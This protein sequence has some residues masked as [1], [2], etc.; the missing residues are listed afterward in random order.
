MKVEAKVTKS[1]P[2]R[3][4][5]KWV[6]GKGRL[7][8]Q[9]AQ[10]FPEKYDEYYEPFVGGGAVYFSLNSKISHI[11]DLNKVLIGLYKIIRD[12]PDSLIAELTILQSEYLNCKS[13]DKK[14]EYFLKKR[15]LFNSIETVTLEK[16]AL[17]IF[18]NKT[19]FNGMYRENSKGEF[20]IPFGKHETPTICDV[21]N[22]LN[23][24]KTLRH[25]SI[26]SKSYEKAVAKA[27]VGDFVY[28]DPPY[29]PIN[30]TS[31]F[32]SYHAD[33]FN[34]EDQKKLCE[35]FGELAKRGCKVMLSNSD[36]PLIN[37][38]YKK[39]NIHKIYAARNINANGEKRGKI[40]EVVITNY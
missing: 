14:K 1:V 19:C 32:T 39:Y 2:A 25:T 23:V 3:P 31:S 34:E 21:S 30:A 10:Y 4:F 40:T 5:L 33:G 27:K 8:P 15:N 16:T 7:V 36:T 24:S 17:L 37:E 26:T 29:H 28:F 22:I 9:L 20:N 13:L 38:I 6:G 35:L 18:L 11:N 12:E